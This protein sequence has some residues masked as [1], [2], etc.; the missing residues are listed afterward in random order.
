M[1][2][3]YAGP[4][5]HTLEL[6]LTIASWD[7]RPIEI[8]DDSGKL[9]RADVALHDDGAGLSDGSMHMVNFYRADGTSRFTSLMRLRGS[10]AG[11][12]GAF[13]LLGDGAYDGTAAVVR[14]RVIE[15]SGTAELSGISGTATSDSSHADYPTM[16]LT[17]TYRFD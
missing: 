11:R 10:L 5:D 4:V 9:T 2:R 12:A 8:F 15:G 17:L 16:P 14:F 13:V 3:P 6:R 1:A 7:E